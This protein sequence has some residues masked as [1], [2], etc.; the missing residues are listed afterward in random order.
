MLDLVDILKKTE[1]QEVEQQKITSVLF[2]QSEQCKSLVEEAF[3][4]EGVTLPAILKNTDEDIRQH[5][6]EATIEIVIVELN[7]S[8]NV[9][10]DMKRIS[11]LLPNHASVIV[12]GSE[13]AISTI[14]N[15]KEMGFYYLFWP[16][17]KAELIDFVQNVN[18]NRE[19]NSG[20]GK[21]RVAKRI[22]VWGSKGGVGA[23][24]LTAEMALELST[25]KNS[26]CLIIDH[27]FSGGNLDILMGINQFEKRSV[28][29]G[30]LTSNLD[31]AYALSMTKKVSKMLTVLAI[32]SDDLDEV[33]MKEYVRTLSNY[34]A[35]QNN[36]IIEDLSC[37]ANSYS[38]LK[39][40]AK[41]CDAMVMVIE[42]TVSSLR[43]AARTMRRLEE[44]GST[45]RIL[46]VL[47]HTICQKSSTV[48]QQDVEKYLRQSINVVCPHE[49]K[50]G[51]MIL[52]GKHLFQQDYPISQSLN[53]LTALL[54]G[55]AIETSKA[56]LLKRLMKRA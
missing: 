14:R 49:P 51:R 13:D 41:E 55:E 47:N 16:V 12:I 2:H 27:N 38:D 45:A 28:K 29:P 10:E 24:M 23:T 17:S 56:P 46:I 43:E 7:L 33:Q 3:R 5:V 15:L 20:L 11:H 1:K 26:S 21:H 19:R 40:V 31:A 4:F 25:N 54:L 34:L 6:R 30:S 39:Y 50:L 48:T 22:A 52:D 36:F 35:S 37:S 53:K 44:L 32:E 18:D 9:T 42:P 8:Q